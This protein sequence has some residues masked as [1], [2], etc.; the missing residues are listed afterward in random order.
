MSSGRVAAHRRI[1]RGPGLPI[2]LRL[3]LVVAIVILGAAVVFAGVGALGT[4]VAGIGSAFSS[5]I[6]QVTVS[7]SP[8]PSEALAPNAPT[9]TQPAEP[10]TNETSIDL[11]GTVPAIYVGQQGTTIR[12]YRAV[13]G[14]TADQVDEIAVGATPG[15]TF[16]GVKLTKGRND[17][18]ATLV[19]DGGE[20]EPSHIVTY[21]LDTTKPKITILKPA[22]DSLVNGKTVTIKGKTQAHSDLVAKNVSNNA[23]VTATAGDDGAFSLVLAIGAG[24]NSI[25]ITATDPAGNV[26]TTTL[27]L[28]RGS[29]RL[30]ATITAS[31]YQF[32]RPSLPDP[33]TLTVKVTNPDGRALDGATVEFTLS[34]PGV[35]PITHT[36]V[37]NGDGIASWKTIIPKTGQTGQGV[38]AALVTTDSFGTT[39]T[40]TVIRIV[41]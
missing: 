13:A 16:P 34:I 10:Y 14:G 27:S 18:S 41:K 32:R 28:R 6:Q 2:Y 4:V 38:A 19:G 35:A 33:I 23:S 25:G 9:L 7:P 17:F 15:F 5:A 26:G 29:G 36:L 30:S 3:G 21:V 1:D 39:T 11:S 31:R 24:Q 22:N 37:T 8:S 12:L 40:Q 20:S